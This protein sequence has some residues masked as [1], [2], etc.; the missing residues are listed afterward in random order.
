MPDINDSRGRRSRHRFAIALL[1]LLLVILCVQP[2]SAAGIWQ[3]IYDGQVWSMD[4]FRIRIMKVYNLFK[5]ICAPLAVCSIAAGGFEVLLGSES[6]QAK[7]IAR[8][9]FTLMAVVALYLLPVI[10]NFGYDI[11]KNFIWDPYHPQ[12]TP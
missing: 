8:I 4:G 12:V 10:I 6:D 3:G 5:A 1:L 7:G 11:A 2:A 9:K